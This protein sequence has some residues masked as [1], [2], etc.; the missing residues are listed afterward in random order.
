M[1]N[2][3]MTPS[4]KTMNHNLLS[5]NSILNTITLERDTTTLLQSFAYA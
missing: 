2:R 3:E 5:D 4:H 1:K